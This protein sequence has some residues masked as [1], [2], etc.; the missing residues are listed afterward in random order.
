MWVCIFTK[1][2][3]D[4]NKARGYN[5]I[6]DTTMVSARS[7]EFLRCCSHQTLSDQEKKSKKKR[8]VC[9][10]YM[11]VTMS[12]W[13]L[14]SAYICKTFL[15]FQVRENR[16]GVTSKFWAPC[17]C[18][19]PQSKYLVCQCGHVSRCSCLSLCFNRL[20]PGFPHQCQS[21]TP[22]LIPAALRCVTDCSV[23]L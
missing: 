12:A 4:K 19:P 14:A 10:L 20:T 11:H 15:R 23:S 17:T 5:I 22:A 18:L 9:V 16:G 7:I 1:M 21:N 2:F 13:H 3:W 8:C 6:H